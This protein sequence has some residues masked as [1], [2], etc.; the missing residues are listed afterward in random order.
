VLTGAASTTGRGAKVRDPYGEIP[1]YTSMHQ[2]SF[3]RAGEDAYVVMLSYDFTKIGVDG[4][5]CLVGF[6]QGVDAIDP[7]TGNP[8]PNRNLYNFRLDYE[9]S[10]GPL[11]GFRMQIFY[12][13]EKLLNAPT[14]RQ[15]QTQFRA[16]VNYL[17]P[18]L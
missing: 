17:M 4:L 13:D 9:P 14:P 16:V 7:S 5:K 15:D 2:S 1:V 12:A 18:L 3:E 8:L 10:K 6:G 11:E